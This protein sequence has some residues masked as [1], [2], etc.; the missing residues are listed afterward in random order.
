MVFSEMGYSTAMHNAAYI[1][2]HES[3]RNA[4]VSAGQAAGLAFT[5]QAVRLFKAAAELGVTSSKLELGDIFFGLA[6]YTAAWAYYEDASARKSALAL[7][8]MGWMY[9]QGLGVPE[10][11]KLSRDAYNRAYKADPNAETPVEL[12]LLWLTVKE[13]SLWWFGLDPTEHAI[14]LGKHA[15]KRG[16]RL[17][18]EHLE[19]LF[20]PSDL[21]YG[22]FDINLDQLSYI[23]RLY[24]AAS[25]TPCDLVFLVSV[26]IACC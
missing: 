9:Q 25:H 8:N 23:A 19:N 5:E 4:T 15:L 20:E 6:N 13:R 10:D 18:V 22:N 14:R 2:Q 12:A 26:F 11:F 21:L 17:D 24:N 1:L 16:P 3:A 7:F